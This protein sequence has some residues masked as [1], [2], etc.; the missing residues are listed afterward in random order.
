MNYRYSK[1]NPV[2]PRKPSFTVQVKII[3]GHLNL[4]GNLLVVANLA[5]KFYKSISMN[6]FTKYNKAS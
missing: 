1:V 6:S 2:V 3:L 5:T 4:K